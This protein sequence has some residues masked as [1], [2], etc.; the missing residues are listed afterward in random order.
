MARLVTLEL[1][2]A[3][4]TREPP[5]TLETRGIMVR[6]GV[7]A[8]LAPLVIPEPPETPVIPATMVQA[9]TPGPEEVQETPERRAMPGIRETTAQLATAEPRAEQGTPETPVRLAIWAL[10]AA[11][12]AEEVV[13]GTLSV[14]GQAQAVLVP[15]IPALRGLLFREAEI[16][17]L[18][19]PVG[20]E[21]PFPQGLLEIRAMLGR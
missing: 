11:V 4:E 3:L 12:A 19:L 15:V 17:G 7:A 1:E 20:L 9:V 10:G 16:V 18:A 13:V 21:L 14:P 6:A 8:R 5:E 2:E